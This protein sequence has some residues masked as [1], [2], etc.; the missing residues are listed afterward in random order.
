MI[1]LILLTT[2]R[3]IIHA[4]VLEMVWQAAA[5]RRLSR[6]A[7]VVHSPPG[8]RYGRSL[9]LLVAASWLCLFPFVNANCQCTLITWWVILWL[10]GY[11]IRSGTQSQTVM[12]FL[13]CC[14]PDLRCLRPGLQ[15]LHHSDNAQESPPGT[16]NML[17][18]R[19]RSEPCTGSTQ[20]P[21]IGTPPLEGGSLDYGPS[22]FPLLLKNR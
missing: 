16:Y 13:R 5:S 21:T 8:F 6:C 3:W 22:C 2:E 12:F 18:L 9:H 1:W 15:A 4:N 10:W 19:R 7:T 14:G 11:F 20:T 17:Y